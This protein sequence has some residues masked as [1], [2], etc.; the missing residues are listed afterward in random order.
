VEHGIS[1]RKVVL[2]NFAD[3]LYS[4]RAREDL[5]AE[6]LAHGHFAI[7]GTGKGK[8]AFVSIP[9]P[10]R[11]SFPPSM[12]TVRIRN[13]IPDWVRPHMSHDEQGMLTAVQ[14][15]NLIARYLGLQSAFRLQSHRRKGVQ[16]Y[17]QVEVDELY[18]GRT[19]KAVEVGIAVEAKSEAP[20]DCLNVSQLFGTAQA[21]K[22]LFP[23]KM[24]KRLVGA[25][26]DTSRRICLAEFSV[27]D[28]PA[29]MR[30][31]KAWV[32]YELV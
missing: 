21:L 27:P 32:A 26:P 28:H 15:N 11:F 4:F 23:P 5:P 25:K 18:V 10:N 22:V 29:E 24:R 13:V 3:A 12:P 2:K 7:I 31:I 9:F 8:Y 17:G 6:I 30:Q 1:K 14:S 20:N 16:E 19:K